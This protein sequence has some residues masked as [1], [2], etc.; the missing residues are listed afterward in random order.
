MAKD[1]MTINPQ[2][3][4]ALA[5]RSAGPMVAVITLK[6][7]AHAR[8]EAPGT[9]KQHIRPIINQSVSAPLGIVMCD[10]PATSFVINGTKPHD[11]R[12]RTRKVLRF[13]SRSGT[14][15][16]R[17]VHHPGTKPNNFLMRALLAARS[18]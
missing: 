14:V 12:P 7:A 6:A 4:G 13:E 15:Y 5:R 2:A 8:I 18:L 1:F 11:I 16:A 3:A 10:H 9:M 17:V